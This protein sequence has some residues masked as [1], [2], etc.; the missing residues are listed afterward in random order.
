MGAYLTEETIVTVL[1]SVLTVPKALP[2]PVA[3][4]P[5]AAHPL[6]PDRFARDN[7]D[8]RNSGWANAWRGTLVA[9]LFLLIG[10]E[11]PRP[12]FLEAIQRNCEQGTVEDCTML[13]T[14]RPATTQDTDIAPT[15]HSHEIVQ[16]IL[17][18]MRQ[19]RLHA[20]KIYQEKFPPRIKEPVGDRQ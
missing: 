20:D 17:A 8:G 15:V 11:Q 16:A 5:I 7:P 10:C 9:L 14:I 3:P 6:A 1:C 12:S 4:N 19:S 13:N 2:G 18:G